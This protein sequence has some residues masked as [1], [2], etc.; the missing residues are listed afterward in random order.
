M[1]LVLVETRAVH[2]VAYLSAV[3]PSVRCWQ[4]PTTPQSSR[5]PQEP[6]GFCLGHL[7]EPWPLSNHLP[8]EPFPSLLPFLLMSPPNA[9]E[10]LQCQRKW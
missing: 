9:I 5:A 1:T 8:Q 10:P 4:W 3:P 6:G 7:Q 2:G